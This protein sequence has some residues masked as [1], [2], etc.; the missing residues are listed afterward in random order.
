[1]WDSE[2]K[3]E[4]NG[5]KFDNDFFH[6]CCFLMISDTSPAG[7]AVGIMTGCGVAE[8]DFLVQFRSILI[9]FSALLAS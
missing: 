2:E 9:S 4:K 6:A 1:M 3:G 5:G 7:I 8:I